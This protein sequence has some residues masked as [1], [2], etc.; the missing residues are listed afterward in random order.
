MSMQHLRA[1]REYEVDQVRPLMPVGCRVLEIGSGAGWQAQRLADHGYQ[2]AAI[3]VPDNNYSHVLIYPTVLYDGRHMPFGDGMFHVVFT[4][5]VLEHV[6]GLE[7]LFTEIRRVLRPGGSAIHILPTPSWRF[8]TS[9]THFV[10]LLRQVRRY[11]PRSFLR[12]L[13][14]RR[15]GERGNLVTELYFFSRVYWNMVFRVNGWEVVQ[16][17]PNRMFYTGYSIL[18]SRLRL[19]QRRRLARLLGSACS[20]F[21]LKDRLRA[22]GN[23]HRKPPAQ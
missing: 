12:A 2:V 7:P 13:W 22:E 9:G 17:L 19:D 10:H 16:Y 14:Q 15:H 23:G 6:A 21:V 1:I 11:R 18:D 8:W 3:N 5:N 20:T 4:S